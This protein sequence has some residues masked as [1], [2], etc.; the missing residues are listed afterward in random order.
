MPSNELFFIA[1]SGLGDMFGYKTVNGKFESPDIYFWDH[2][3]NSIKWVAPN[4]IKFVEGWTNG[5]ISV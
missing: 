1:D 2:E 4:L 3:E 5:T